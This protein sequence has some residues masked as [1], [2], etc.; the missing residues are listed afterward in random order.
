M[1]AL[2]QVRDLNTSGSRYSQY[3]YHF[4][5]DLERDGV[6]HGAAIVA[7]GV[8]QYKLTSVSQCQ[9]GASCAGTADEAKTLVSY[10]PQVTGTANTLLPV[11]VTREAGDG[12]IPATTAI[13]YD[14]IGNAT[15]ADGPLSGSDDTVTYRYDA[16]RRRTGTIA[17][18]PDGAGSRNRAAERI[19]SPRPL[20][21]F[22]PFR[23]DRACY[24][25]GLASM[26]G[27]VSEPRRVA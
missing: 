10:G 24:I 13:A 15:A 12:T 25:N 20:T 3:L 9:T 17:P 16:D 27:A 23:R 19:C 6:R 1:L 14:M 5:R 26:I 18:D 4:G 8:T 21:L 11:S 22:S 2:D 7:S